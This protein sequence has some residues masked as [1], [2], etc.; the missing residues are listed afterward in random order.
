MRI[1]CCFF[2]EVTNHGIYC[3]TGSVTASIFPPG[4]V[5]GSMVSRGCHGGVFGPSGPRER[6]DRAEAGAVS[7]QVSK[8]WLLESERLLHKMWNWILRLLPAEGWPWLLI[9]DSTRIVVGFN[10]KEIISDWGN[11]I[12]QWIYRMGLKGNHGMQRN[13]TLIGEAQE[14]QL[15]CYIY[16]R[17]EM[18]FLCA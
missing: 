2:W 3:C 14:K 7:H 5:S 8:V 11:W 18:L 1:F 13:G 9:V 16:K 12:Q 17:N 6:N 15:V 4:R 10:W